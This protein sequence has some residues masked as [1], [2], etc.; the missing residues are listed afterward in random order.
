MEGGGGGAGGG[1]RGGGGGGGPGG[2]CTPT[3]P[4]PHRPQRSTFLVDQRFKKESGLIVFF[5][6]YFTD[7]VV[8]LKIL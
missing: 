2:A 5:K 8:N 7:C 1:G 3:P 6:S 4:P